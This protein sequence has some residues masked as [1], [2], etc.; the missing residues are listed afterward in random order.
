MSISCYTI[1]EY[2]DQAFSL[3]A[4]RRFSITFLCSLINCSFECLV[5]RMKMCINRLK[6]SRPTAFAFTSPNSCRRYRSASRDFSCWGSITERGSLLSGSFVLSSF[7]TVEK[8]T[9]AKLALDRR[10]LLPPC[11]PAGLFARSASPRLLP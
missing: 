2:S 11:L 5:I 6:E 10:A 7:F 9:F 3:K 8:S 1:L 4:L